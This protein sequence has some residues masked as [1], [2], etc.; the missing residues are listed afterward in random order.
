M[1]S[2]PQSHVSRVSLEECL[3]AYEYELT[4]MGKDLMTLITA[5]LQWGD[6]WIFGDGREPLL[7]LDRCSGQRIPQVRFLDSEVV[8]LPPGISHLRRARGRAKGRAPAT[9]QREPARRFFRLG[10]TGCDG[11]HDLLSVDEIGRQGKTE[12]FLRKPPEPLHRHCH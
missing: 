9:V 12:T 6:R 1:D 3:Q 4:P 8:R 5:L 2:V 10:P 7:L 11:H